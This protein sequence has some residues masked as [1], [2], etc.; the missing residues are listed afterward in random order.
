M[1][2]FLCTPEHIHAIVGYAAYHHVPYNVEPYTLAT[3]LAKEN[4]RSVEYRYPDTKGHAACEFLDF[5]NNRAYIA[6]C[7]DPWHLSNQQPP[8]PPKFTPVEIIKLI[9]SLDY[10]SCETPNW[11]KTTA[12]KWL[13]QIVRYAA[14]AIDPVKYENAQWAL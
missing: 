9:D 11:E 8:Q 7:A 4:L 2:A 1:S 5:K 13:N 10:Q 6:A 3:T 14:T 12:Y